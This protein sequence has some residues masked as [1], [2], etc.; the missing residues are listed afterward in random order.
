MRV[1]QRLLLVVSAIALLGWALAPQVML[2][3]AVPGARVAS[4][5]TFNVTGLKGAFALSNN[6]LIP[7]SLDNPSS[8]SVPIPITGLAM[9]ENLVDID[10]RPINGLMYGL[11]VNAS[12]QVRLYCI[13]HRNGVATPLA[14]AQG[15]VDTDGITPRPV[16]GTVGIDIN[17]AVDRL[18][19]V[20][21]TGLNFRMNPNTGLLIDGDSMAPGVQPDANI[22]GGTTSVDSTLYTNNAGLATVTTQYTLDPGTDQMF[23]Q[24]P[25]NSG[26]QVLGLP[27]TV[28]ASPLDFTR[29]GGFDVPDGVNTSSS[30][31]PVTSGLAFA[32]LQVD[33]VNQLYAI[34]L[35]SG[36]A[37]LIG[38]VG[39]GM[40]PVQGLAIQ[41]RPIDG[42][43]FA[44]LLSQAGTSLIQFSQG[45][46]FAQEVLIS[47]VIGGEQLV[48]IDYRPATGQFYALGINSSA[49]NGTLY[50]ADPKTGACSPIAPSAVAFV[51]DDGATPVSLPSG[52]YGMDFNPVVDRVRVTT[53]SGLNFRLN[54]DNGLPIDGNGSA[55][56][57][58]TDANINGL[59]TGSTGVSATAYTNSFG[60]ATAT[61]QYTIDAVSRAL[62]IQSPPN[63]GTQLFVANITSNNLPLAVDFINGFDISPNVRTR[64]SNVPVLGGSGLLFTSTGE[65]SE[66]YSLDLV[67]GRAN[68][69]A[70]FSPDVPGLA[71]GT[72]ASRLVT[73]VTKIGV[74]RST[75][76][77]AFVRNTNTSGPAD[78]AFAYGLPGDIPIAGD[79]DGDGVD[80]IGVFRP[81]TAQFLLKNTNTPGPAD[82]AFNYGAPGD[83][84]VVGDWT[85]KGFDSVGVFRNGVFFLRDSNTAGPA[86]RAV[87]YGQATDLPVVGDWDGDGKTSVGVFRNGEFFLKNTNTSGVADF[88]FRYGLPG[89][90]PVAGDWTGKGFDSVGV[91][92]NGAFF[93]RN[94]NTSG[95]A[96]FLVNFGSAGDQPI[97]GDWNGEFR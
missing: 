94:S 78:A 4:A 62:Y 89:D 66:I 58:Q 16:S 76:A 18:R 55:L 41:T 50:L 24:N 84:P 51:Q 57:T 75:T 52:R 61:T 13:S 69:L 15:L 85:G 31:T 49:N 3:R 37:R 53:N 2:E 92:R 38:P 12:G 70:Q 14:P 44:V 83:L 20:T 9:G 42:G 60:G 81:S 86:D 67:T 87:N 22:N 28:D 35:P 90:R 95:N 40:T 59:P 11:A 5:G 64:S 6:Q 1:N 10:F 79:W 36:A 25:P 72:V 48:G 46:P 34:A 26:T 77:T 91:F 45:S 32:V 63:S 73:D 65:R 7:L 29:V 74:Y 30:G 8:P 21:S 33:G 47:G 56:G 97:V 27:V 54:P 93:L 88:A 17:P 43:E 96:D 68:L 19:I 80:T 23:I 39:N 71:G 82:V